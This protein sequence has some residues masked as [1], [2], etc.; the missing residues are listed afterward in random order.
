[1]QRGRLGQWYGWLRW[2]ANVLNPDQAA[3]SVLDHRMLGIKDFGLEVCEQL[4]AQG[5]LTLQRPIGHA[6]PTA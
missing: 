3:V 6:S 1:L 2:C 4:V 5:K